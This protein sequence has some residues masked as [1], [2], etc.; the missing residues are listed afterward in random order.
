[1][2]LGTPTELSTG[3]GTA[4]GTTGTITAST[5]DLIY[6]ALESRKGSGPAPVAPSVTPPSNITFTSI[7]SIAGSAGFNRV[8]LWIG[9]ATGSVSGTAALTFGGVGVWAVGKIT[10][11]DTTTPVPAGQSNTAA[12]SGSSNPS[13]AVGSSI[14]STSYLMGV[15][16]V[17]TIG[18]T[19][20][21]P[22]A[23]MSQ[24][25][26]ANN[27]AVPQIFVEVSTVAGLP[28]TTA[29]STFSSGVNGSMVV[30]EIAA[31]AGGGGAPACPPAILAY[32]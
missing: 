25:D 19:T 3:T 10:G 32:M 14:A 26:I 21:L 17:D 18:V 28:L 11:A 15:I 4:S 31:A 7:G 1:M 6:I 27:T 8:T 5:G 20:T 2:A 12:F 30:C 9:I 29:G 16:G 24:I 23:A 13:A 22:G